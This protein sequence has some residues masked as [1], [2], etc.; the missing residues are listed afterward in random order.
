MSLRLLPGSF[1]ALFALAGAEALATGA[2][3]G[4]LP[5]ALTAGSGSKDFTITLLAQ[6]REMEYS[7]KIAFGASSALR[8]ALNENPG[9][10]VLH[11]NSNGGSV[12]WA[13]Q[14]QYLV[15]ERGLTTVIDS[16]CLSAC[17]LVF[18]AGRERYLA[19]GAKLGFHR[20]SAPEMSQ[21]EI[22]MV[23]ETDAQYMKAMGISSDFVD[24]AFS[25]SSSNIW[26]PTADELKA[27]H[28]ITDVSTKFE[29][30]DDVKPP[31]N[32]A[33]QL[34]AEPPF[35][36]LRQSAGADYGALRDRALQSMGEHPAQAD[37]GNLP[38]RE[39]APLSLVFVGHAGDELVLEFTRAFAAYLNR[40]GAKDADACFYVYFPERAPA[41]FRPV[42]LLEGKE[43]EDFADLQLRL[44]SDGAKRNLPV[45]SKNDVG[46]AL[47]AMAK[48]FKS[49][50]PGLVSAFSDV[51][52][53][54]ADHGA[55]CAA[56]A[57]MFE[58]ALALPDA[59]RAPLLRYLF[60]GD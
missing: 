33:D 41:D 32:L 29:T 59:Q 12:G 51:D 34:L 5:A 8:S 18:L 60:A 22:N 26:I 48:V 1:C 55:S 11:L 7:G 35:D 42:V 43:L 39:I 54:N 50:H 36:S 30:P 37:V 45:P 9:V 24:K 31:A 46:G 23:E 4:D 3:A 21:A 28:V 14:M 52:S 38:T 58:S 19:P 10:A 13:R 56:M 20:E 47:G 16:H 49:A 17:A 27:A 44:V 25:I 15:H 57:A 53:A 6:G 2:R 40:L